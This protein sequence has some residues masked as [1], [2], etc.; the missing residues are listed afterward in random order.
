MVRRVLV[1]GSNRGIGLEVVKALLK[2]PDIHVLLGARDA[3]RGRTA[4]QSLP[5]Y[6]DGRV[7]LLH[8]DVGD[9]ASIQSAAQA[10]GDKYGKKNSL[11]CLVNNAGIGS[12]FPYKEV[13]KVCA[14][15]TMLVTDA[16]L[17]Y[18]EEKGRVVN[19]GSISGVTYYPKVSKEWQTKLLQPQRS[20]L[21][22]LSKFVM[23]TEDMELYEKE[24]LGDWVSD[25]NAYS[26][27]KIV[28]CSH[29]AMLAKEY[30]LRKCNAIEPG[31]VET[32]FTGAMFQRMGRD[33]FDQWGG[34]IQ[35]DQAAKVYMHVI[36][37]EDDVG[38]GYLYSSDCK[39]SHF[40]QPRK[41]GEPEYTE[42]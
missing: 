10:F 32:E 29:A 3:D 36:L 2:V 35:A 12:K 21:E 39:R 15:G 8:I 1:T 6:E 34:I 5:G 22:W 38:S 33:V 17:P 31:V 18:L 28:V 26:L 27:A 25:K 30:P 11:Y 13:W 19:V 42:S 9:P 4:V 41:P 40:G 37:N 14:I 7:E 16:F 23:E 24:G 20:D